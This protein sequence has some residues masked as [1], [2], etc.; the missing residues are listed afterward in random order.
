M[1]PVQQQ[2]QYNQLFGDL[3]SLEQRRKALLDRAS[4]L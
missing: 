1:N 3:V 4:G 2:T